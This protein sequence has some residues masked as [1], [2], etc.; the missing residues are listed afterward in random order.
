MSTSA[1]GANKEA[2]DRIAE[3]FPLTFPIPSPLTHKDLIP[4]DDLVFEQELLRNPD[5]IRTWMDYISHVDETNYR[6][7]PIPDPE[8]SSDGVK[9]LGF[10]SDE[11]L[12]LALQRI[13]GLYERALSVFPTS[14][15]LWRR[16][17]SARAFFVL[18]EP[19]DGSAGRRQRLLQPPI[20]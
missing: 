12:R 8:M 6:K 13:V 20:P 16:Y 1:N 14:Y 7:R 10:L 4:L 3:S 19:H 2:I 15:K 17:L 9:L 18:G 5:N 11:A